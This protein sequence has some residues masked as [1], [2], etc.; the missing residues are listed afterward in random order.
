MKL[1]LDSIIA[2]EKL[3]HYLLKHRDV[4][5]KSKL[6][7]LAG[8]DRTHADLLE[9]DIRALLTQEAQPIETTEYVEKFSITGVLFGPN[10]RQLR[11]RTIWARLLTTGATRFVTLYPDRS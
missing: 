5:D 6:L 1:S 2:P 11:V 7:S 9:R 3:H 4:D 8:Y 10:G